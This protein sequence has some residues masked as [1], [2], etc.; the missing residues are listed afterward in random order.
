M[1][2]FINSLEISRKEVIGTSLQ[3]YLIRIFLPFH[4]V[5]SQWHDSPKFNAGVQKEFLRHTVSQACLVLGRWVGQIAC[6]VI[7]SMWQASHIKLFFNIVSFGVF[8]GANFT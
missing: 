8:S 4:Y 6:L 1:A 5:Q 3:Q 7:S 2:N